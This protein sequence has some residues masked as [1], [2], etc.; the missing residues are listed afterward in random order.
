MTHH[1]AH[2]P[3]IIRA[4]ISGNRE[5]LSARCD[6]Y[7]QTHC[8][9][10]QPS[11]TM[12]TCSDSRVHPHVVMP[13]AIDRIFTIENIGNQIATSAGSV[14]YGILHLKT[15]L[16]LILGHTCCGAISA[17]LAGFDHEPDSIK[18]EL[19]GLAPALNR[20]KVKENG[21]DPV[22]EGTL[23]NIDYQV[24]SAIQ[25]YH[26]LVKRQELTV[27]GAIYDISDQLGNGH[28]HLAF[29]N[30]N[31]GLDFTGANTVE[32]GDNLWLRRPVQ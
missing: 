26:N 18:R 17:F 20:I 22:L 31:N 12:V 32:F 8:Q 1:S 14:D 16:L 30:L 13:D 10:Q 3:D 4:L 29:T 15:P 21:N 11:I 23:A 2:I 6:S 19:E 28:G 5:F 9:K 25:R 27:M 7:F 24:E